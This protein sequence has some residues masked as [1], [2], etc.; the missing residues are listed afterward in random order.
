MANTQTVYSAEVEKELAQL[1]MEL[2]EAET[3]SA[4]SVAN[5]GK[6]SPEAAGKVA[7]ILQRIHD[8]TG[9]QPDKAINWR[10]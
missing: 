7:D 6:A 1:R 2:A 3:Q 5:S 8:I 9:E 10:Q 4:G